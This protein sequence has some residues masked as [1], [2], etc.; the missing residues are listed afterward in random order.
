MIGY[1][2][3]RN[4]SRFRVRIRREKSEMMRAACTATFALAFV[5]ASNYLPAQAAV[6]TAW[7]HEGHGGKLA[8]ATT[9]KGDRIADFSSAGYEGG[10]VALPHVPQ[11][12]TVTPS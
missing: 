7:V 12:R 10:G 1:V 5:C 8:Y 11:K 2:V 4:H 3:D 6:P 9:P